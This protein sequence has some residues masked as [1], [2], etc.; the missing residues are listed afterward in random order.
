[1]LTLARPFLFC[2]VFLASC[3]PAPAPK[4]YV[5]KSS[6]HGARTAPTPERRLGINLSS[7]VDWSSEWPFVDAF[8]TSRPWMETGA[9]PFTYDDRGNPLLRPLQTVGTLVFRNVEGKFP[10][11]K[12]VITYQGN[13]DIDVKHP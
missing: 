1:M 5:S 12:Y 7:V 13:G 11:G 4:K 9:G 2:L 6:G 10:K 3:N 8:K